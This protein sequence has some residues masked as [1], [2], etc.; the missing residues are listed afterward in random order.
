M[1]KG[2]QNFGSTD[3]RKDAELQARIDTAYDRVRAEE[4]K[5]HPD[6]KIIR[7]K[8]AEMEQLRLEAQKLYIPRSFLRSSGRT[9]RSA[10]M[11][12]PARIRRSTPP[13]CRPI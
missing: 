13:P 1:F 4:A 9:A 7:E 2:T 10:S 8:L 6:P 11:P 12:S 5:R 3:F